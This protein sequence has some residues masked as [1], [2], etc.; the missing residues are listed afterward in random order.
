ME[1]QAE[2]APFAFF[3]GTSSIALKTKQGSKSRL[4]KEEGIL[5]QRRCQGK[6]VD[7]K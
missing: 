5:G 1:R 2:G 6:E 3:L 7:V 4:R